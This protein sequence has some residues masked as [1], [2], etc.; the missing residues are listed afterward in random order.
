MISHLVCVCVCVCV[1]ACVRVCVVTVDIGLCIV[2]NGC[3]CVLVW[4]CVVL[5]VA[6]GML[7]CLC[8]FGFVYKQQT[9]IVT[10]QMQRWSSRVVAQPIASD[11]DPPAT[12]MDIRT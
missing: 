4:F 11:N 5:C 12:M 1:C 6:H 10:S 3:A 7:V 8:L 2:L 9:T